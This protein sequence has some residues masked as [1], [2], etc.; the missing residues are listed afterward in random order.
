MSSE[1]T[2]KSKLLR[3]W[4]SLCQGTRVPPHLSQSQYEAHLTCSVTAIC[5]SDNTDPCK[6]LRTLFLIHFSHIPGTSP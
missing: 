3:L 1:V 5:A 2:L 6:S 4:E